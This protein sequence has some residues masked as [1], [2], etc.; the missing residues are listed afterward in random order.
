MGNYGEV[1]WHSS[2]WNF[3]PPVG[4]IYPS[5]RLVFGSNKHNHTVED[6]GDVREAEVQPTALE[7]NIV[8]FVTP[9]VESGETPLAITAVVAAQD[10]PYVG[11]RNKILPEN[12]SHVVHV[13]EEDL[14]PPKIK[15][16]ICEKI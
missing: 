9:V 5:T 8:D 12:H 10:P 7:E 14:E 1:N 16:K 2:H 13:V 4:W 3:R 6:A 11:R 15:L